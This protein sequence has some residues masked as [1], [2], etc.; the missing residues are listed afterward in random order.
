MHS[1]GCSADDAVAMADAPHLSAARRRL[2]PID[3]RGLGGLAEICEF[4]ATLTIPRN[5]IGGYPDTMGDLIANVCGG[6]ILLFRPGPAPS[7]K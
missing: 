2:Q 4:I 5:G 7:R 6:A 1:L 3:V